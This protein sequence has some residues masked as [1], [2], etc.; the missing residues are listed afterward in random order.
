MRGLDEAFSIPLIELALPEPTHCYSFLPAVLF[1]F[2]HRVVRRLLFDLLN[3]FLHIE[4]GDPRPQ[5]ERILCYD[6]ALFELILA[7]QLIHT[8]S[9]SIILRDLKPALLE[10]LCWGKVKCESPL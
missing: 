10:S 3:V 2:G 5:T 8:E 1:L 9:G 4:I 7:L 6:S